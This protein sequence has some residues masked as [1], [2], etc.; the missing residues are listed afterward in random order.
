[1]HRSATSQF[2]QRYAVSKKDRG[3]RELTHTFFSGGSFILPAE[4]GIEGRMFRAMA[5]DV[6]R[7][8]PFFVNELR[9]PF[10]RMFLDLD[11][12]HS[13]RLTGEEMEE[14]V[15]VVH[16][17]FSRFFPK[18]STQINERLFDIIVLDAPPVPLCE[19]QSDLESLCEKKLAF[20]DG[21]KV[22][23][24]EDGNVN[25][26][27]VEWEG[28]KEEE[29]SY[30]AEVDDLDRSK[31]VL[32][33][34]LVRAGAEEE[35]EGRS[36]KNFMRF[37]NGEVEKYVV[38]REGSPPP[39]PLKEALSS[40]WTHG[41]ET[42][43][44]LG[45]GKIILNTK[46]DDSGNVKHG[47]HVICPNLIVRTEEALFMREALIEM[48]KS[49]FGKKFSGGRDE[50]GKGFEE[51]IDN[52][53]YGSSCGLRMAGSHKASECSNCRGKR[54]IDTCGI[55]NGFGKVDGGR[56]YTLHSAYRNGVSDGGFKTA[57]SS[58][59]MLFFSQCSIRTRKASVSPGWSR[60]PGCP[61]Y[62]DALKVSKDGQQKIVSRVATF[63]EDS[64]GLGSKKR[65]TV[66]DPSKFH[67]FESYIRNRFSPQYKSLR[68]RSVDYNEEGGIYFVE[69][70]GEGRHWCLNKLPPSDHRSNSIYFTCDKNG[71]R[72]RC[73]CKSLSASGK[74][75]LCKNFKS[76]NVSLRSDHKAAL[77]PWDVSS[78]NYLTLSKEDQMKLMLSHMNKK[79]K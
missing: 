64:G 9:S 27:R 16:A 53:V 79:R 1:M 65:K 10:F 71:I 18:N 50:E 47:I 78:N 20:S 13:S 5:T 12:Y 34:K 56:P 59:L 45:G 41:P 15:S 26:E 43:F 52:A 75:G 66:V 60:F 70:E 23:V 40:S 74:K 35:R 68:V 48:M 28:G 73:H 19:T 4:D 72:L 69:V 38:H 30:I 2:F 54:N 51:V 36:F 44:D 11:L 58:N 61:S 39:V 29:G 6:A 62:G 55:C 24:T 22:F 8:V 42:R 7:G 76:D 33:K 3:G 67:I 77:F 46:K 63:K 31:V 32:R 17:C 37:A 14:I 49:R 21:E 57:L 25:G